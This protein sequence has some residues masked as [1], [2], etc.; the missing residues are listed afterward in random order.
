MFQSNS[1][2]IYIPLNHN[3]LYPILSY[4][5][6]AAQDVTNYKVCDNTDIFDEWHESRIPIGWFKENIQCSVSDIGHGTVKSFVETPK[7]YT[8]TVSFDDLYE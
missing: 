8:F 7:S 3:V 5:P 6:P 1:Y 2:Y 4:V